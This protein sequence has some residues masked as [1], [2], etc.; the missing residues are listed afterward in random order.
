MNTDIILTGAPVAEFIKRLVDELSPQIR[1]II[2]EEIQQSAQN[3]LEEKYIS[4]KE[5]RKILPVT[6]PTFRSYRNQGLFPSYRIGS[7][8][9]YKHAEVLEATK[10]IK[11]YSRDNQLS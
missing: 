8:I 2:R 7:R 11:K 10:R 3:S 4:E 1:L 5:A 6:A 9:F